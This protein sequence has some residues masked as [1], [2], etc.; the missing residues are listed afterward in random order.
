M[1]YKTD[2][3]SERHASPERVRREA[4]ASACEHSFY[5]FDPVCYGHD[6]ASGVD[7]VVQCCR[8]CD[9]RR[10]VDLDTGDVFRQYVAHVPREDVVIEDRAEDYTPRFD[11]IDAFN[12]SEDTSDHINLFDTRGGAG[13]IGD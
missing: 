4:K 6:V 9:T 10:D 11:G 13:G 1:G 7:Y 8:G 2:Y 12:E 5:R 3:S